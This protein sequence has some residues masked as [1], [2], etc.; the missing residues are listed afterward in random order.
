MQENSKNN[1]EQA[2]KKQKKSPEMSDFS[3]GF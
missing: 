2:K 3:F 1:R